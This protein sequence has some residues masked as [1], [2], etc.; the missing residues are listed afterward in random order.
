MATTARLRPPRLPTGMAATPGGSAGVTDTVTVTPDS[1]TLPQLVTDT[2]ARTVGVGGTTAGDAPGTVDCGATH[3]VA[4]MPTPPVGTAGGVIPSAVTTR[5]WK[6]TRAVDGASAAAEAPSAVGP[7]GAV[8]IG[9]GTHTDGRRW[10][11]G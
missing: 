1:G 2:S 7:S 8:A 9:A 11:G 5:W 3:E 4:T 6:G 10:R